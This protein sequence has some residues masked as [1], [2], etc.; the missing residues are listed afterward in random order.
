MLWTRPE[1]VWRDRLLSAVLPESSPLDGFHDRFEEA[2]PAMLRWG[3]RASLIALWL[4]PALTVRRWTVASQLSEKQLD[5]HLLRSRGSS[6]YLLRQ[7]ATVVQLV[8]CFASWE[9]P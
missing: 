9:Q 1:T 8:A 7:C 2:A 5:E 6:N 4:S 3:F